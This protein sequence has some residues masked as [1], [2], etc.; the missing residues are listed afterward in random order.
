MDSDKKKKRQ[1]RKKVFGFIIALLVVA[2]LAALPFILEDAQQTDDSG[3]SILTGRVETG[4]IEKTVSG[5]GTLTA[6]EGENVDLPDGVKVTRYLVSNGEKVTEG[7]QIAAVDKNSVLLAMSKV[8]DA[9]DGIEEQMA[10]CDG[11]TLD[12]IIYSKVKGSVTAVYAEPGDSVAEVM[13]EHGA[14]AVVTLADGKQINI[15]GIDGTVTGVNIKEGGSVFVGAKCFLLEDTSSTG[16][17]TVLLNEHRDY[18]ELMERLSGMYVTGAIEAPCAGAVSGIDDAVAKELEKNIKVIYATPAAFESGASDP[19]APDPVTYKVLVVGSKTQKSCR[20]IEGDSSADTFGEI[21]STILGT[22]DVGTVLEVKL[23]FDT[24]ETVCDRRITDTGLFIDPSWFS[25][26]GNTPSG[27]D[28]PSGGG[29]GGGFSGGTSFG[30]ASMGGFSV[31][32][33]TAAAEDSLYPLT[34]STLMTVTPQE[35]VTVSITVDEMDILAV[36]TGDE[37]VVTV[38]ALPGR[39]FSGTV[40]ERSTSPSNSGGNSKYSAVVTLDRE[41]NMLDGM[42]ASILITFDRSE[43]LLLIPAEAVCEENGKT[44]VY[45]GCDET[46]KILINPVTVKTGLSDGDRVEI[47]SGLALGDEFY[48]EYY[49][50]LEINSILGGM[51]GMPGMPGGANNADS[52][53]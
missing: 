19:S 16:L 28:T 22:Y 12:T 51:P 11:E 36:N 53:N 44:V 50:T 25:Y 17:Y 37:A 23:I 39:S 49:D 20:V 5:A 34:G 3:A 9:I 40:T 21:D 30:G 38:D 1:K 31:A 47:V 41:E 4:A 45:T 52:D 24:S 7:Q 42:N 43:D 48:Y 2:A 8:Q 14:L 6:Q 33:G 32:G 13:A 15:T 18:E 35:K 46:G 10:D 27:G 26:G 29:G